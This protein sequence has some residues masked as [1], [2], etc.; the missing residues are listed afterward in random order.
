M[1]EKRLNNIENSQMSDIAIGIDLGGTRVKAVAI[2][3]LGNMLHQHYQPTFDGDEN[4]W[5]NAVAAAFRDVQDKTGNTDALVV[6]VIGS[7]VF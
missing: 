2:D 5:K 3:G 1:A 7:V 6:Q 4:G